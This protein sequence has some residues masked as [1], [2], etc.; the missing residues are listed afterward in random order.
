MLWSPCNYS[1]IIQRSY[2]HLLINDF[3]QRPLSL[4]IIDHLNYHQGSTDRDDVILRPSKWSLRS[5]NHPDHYGHFQ[6]FIGQFQPLNGYFFDYIEGGYVSSNFAMKTIEWFSVNFI[7]KNKLIYL[8]L[9][10][11]MTIIKSDIIYMCTSNGVLHDNVARI[12]LLT[13]S[14]V[15]VVYPLWP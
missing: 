4:F 1:N 15:V 6:S 9:L 12:I 14:V 8:I 10:P 7:Q 2:T 5:G 3:E 11:I 13:A